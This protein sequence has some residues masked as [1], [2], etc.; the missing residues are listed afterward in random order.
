MSLLPKLAF[1]RI[2]SPSSLR[3]LEVYI[4]FL[5]PF[6]AKIVKS[7]DENVVPRA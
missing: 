2:G 1:Q 5:C 3:T 7:L 6:S 4:D